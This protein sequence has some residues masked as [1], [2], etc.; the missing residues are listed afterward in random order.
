MDGE[1]ENSTLYFDSAIKTVINFEYVLINLFKRF[2][3]E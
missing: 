1:T 2:Y 3:R